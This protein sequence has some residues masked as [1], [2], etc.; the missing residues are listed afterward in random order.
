MATLLKE[1]FEEPADTATLE[2][3]L[4]RSL[5]PDEAELQKSCGIRAI[6][7]ARK[8]DTSRCC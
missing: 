3:A 1:M 5:F 4:D 2:A 6:C 7:H 8:S